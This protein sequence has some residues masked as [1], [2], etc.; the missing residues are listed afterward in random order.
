MQAGI[1][2]VS[3]V[4]VIVMIVNVFYR[5]P[6]ENGRNHSPLKIPQGQLGGDVPL[7]AETENFSKPSHSSYPSAI[8]DR[9]ID[10]ALVF[11]QPCFSNQVTLFDDF[12]KIRLLEH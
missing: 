10:I 2:S 5:F 8:R 9:K 1:T 6:C 11:C 3:L 7:I 12:M 4:I